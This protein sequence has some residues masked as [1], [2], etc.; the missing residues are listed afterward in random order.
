[1]SKYA[2]NK[3]KSTMNVG[4]MKMRAVSFRLFVCIWAKD[5][6]GWRGGYSEWKTHYALTLYLGF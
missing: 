5:G 3:R 6:R 4:L 2:T 1:M